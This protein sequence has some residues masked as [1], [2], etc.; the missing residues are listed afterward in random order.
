[1]PVTGSQKS[2]LRSAVR[3]FLAADSPR[4]AV[5]ESPSE[6]LLVRMRR[7]ILE[8]LRD[9]RDRAIPPIYFYD[10][11][12]SA[13]YEAITA[14]PEYY[15][16]RKEAALLRQIAPLLAES[17]PVTE[18]VELGSGSSTKTRILLDA[19]QEGD[20]PLT[21]IPIDVSR[22][23]LRSVAEALVEEYPALRVLGIAA[24][25]EDAL[26]LL[27][28]AEGRLFLFLGSTIG[29]FSPS[30]QVAF[31]SHLRQAMSPGNDLLLGFDLRAHGR[32]PAAFIQSAYA[33]PQ[34]V[35]ARFN[36]NLLERLNRELGADFALQNWRHQA[37]YAESGDR[38]EMRLVSTRPQAVH[39]AGRAFHFEA[40][41]GILTE[42][43]R[44]FDPEE[45]AAWFSE[46]GFVAS[47]CWLDA[48]E[49]YGLMLLR[50]QE[51]P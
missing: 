2:P 5:L 4:V 49:T 14:L 21:Y 24:P 6:S 37:R 45:L 29:N 27:P 46:R 20:R 40:G 38:I 22:D 10:A 28:P 23:F 12:G 36:L 33:D 13:L 44:K 39:V 32:K 8:G 17:L 51:G 35:T 18:L 47:A 41:E 1:M 26:A 11:K 3:G 31:V 34:G 9:P 48:E 50:R 30:Q 19:F 16:T 43:S 15:L 7:D 25:F 42:I